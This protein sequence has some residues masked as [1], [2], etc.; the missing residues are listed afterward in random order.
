MNE[1]LKIGC[2]GFPVAKEKYFKNFKVVELQQTFY[3]P[4]QINTA[5]KW[6][7][8]A[9]SDFEFTLKAWQLITHTTSSP[10]YRRLKLKIPKDEKKYYGNFKP[11]DE[12]FLAWENTDKLA[13]A[14][15]SKVII[16]QCP[17]SFKPST[18]NLKNMK[19]FFKQIKR[20]NYLFCFEPRAESWTEALIKFVCKDLDLVHCVD[21]FKMKPLFGKIRYLRLHGIGGY[22]YKYTNNDLGKLLDLVKTE[23]LE[24]YVMFNNVYMFEN[25]LKFRQQTLF[26]KKS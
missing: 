12:V 10:T 9:P 13:C 15:N 21:P 3:Q 8:Q 25:A 7:Q 26:L 14:L 24:T 17:V 5:Y 22:N 23:D 16:F 4:P 19:E 11:S 18:E 6:R 1:N 2:C 20:R